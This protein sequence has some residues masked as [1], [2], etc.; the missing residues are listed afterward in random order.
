MEKWGLYIPAM[1]TRVGVYR[2]PCPGCR[3][4]NVLH[5]RRCRFTDRAR[6]EIER[7]HVEI[8]ATLASGP[9]GDVEL[10]QRS[11]PWDGLA[12]ATLRMLERDSRID[13]TTM[14]GAERLELVPPAEIVDR[15]EPTDE[16]LRT[17][18][19]RG[20]VPGAH[21][22]SVFAMVAY[23]S[24]K[25]LSW[26]DTRRRVVEWLHETG[27]WQRGGFEESTPEA[28]VDAK[29][30]VYEEDYGWLEKAKAAKRVVEN[31]TTID[32]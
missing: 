28:L 1:R 12:E 29:R 13:R 31:A 26:E 5:A 27:T 7:T 23:Y 24:A 9:C 21:D 19:E 2:Y 17:I 18:Y 4:T 30:H 14:D 3:S 32:A 6:E 15:I 10:R 11:D 20:S 16:P 8:V 22:N 25:G